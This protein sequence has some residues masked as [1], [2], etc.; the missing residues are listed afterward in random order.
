L[1]LC[2]SAFGKMRRLL[3]GTAPLR[4]RA[5]LDLVVQPFDFRTA[6]RFWGLD[7][8]PTAAFELFSLVGGTP[9]YLRF[10][11]GDRPK[12]GDVS[13]WACRRLLEPS[14]ALFRE[15][16]IV[17]AEDEELTDQKLYWGMLGAVASGVRRWSDIEATLGASR[18]SMAHSLRT[19]M[20]AGWLARRDDPIRKARST[21]ELL[22][23]LVRFHRLVIAPNEQRLAR[24]GD[25]RRVWLD[26]EST[27]A[28]LI[29]GPQLEQLAYDWSL[30]HA[31]PDTFGGTVSLVGPTSLARPMDGG[32]GQSIRDLDFAAVETTSRGARRVLAVGEVKATTAKVGSALLDRIDRVATA[33]EASPPRGTTVTGPLKRVL[34]SRSGFTNDLRRI[35]DQRPDVELIDLRRLYSGD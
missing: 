4:G 32:G 25:A 6:A 30:L 7:S 5:S 35:G 27:V 15:G 11:A 14:S 33:W 24:G 22:E 3:D 34:F 23:P 19:V 31:A 29:Q 18:G 2:G 8:N 16:R 21:Y 1:I 20:D 13:S 9:A 26:A 12:S 28:S 10:V 17:V